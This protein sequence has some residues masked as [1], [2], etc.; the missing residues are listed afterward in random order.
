MSDTANLSFEKAVQTTTCNRQRLSEVIRIRLADF[1]ELDSHEDIGPEDAFADLGTDSRQAVE[2]KIL[3][4]ELFQCRL[5]TTVLF[6]YPTV[7]RLVELLFQKLSTG[8]ATLVED[9]MGPLPD[10]SAQLQRAASTADVHDTRTNFPLSE[11][12]KGLW[13]ISQTLDCETSFN[14]P[15]L[16]RLTQP[17]D[18]RRFDSALRAVAQRHPVMCVQFRVQED[19]G[20][21][22]QQ[23]L[24]VES[25]PSIER[26]WPGEGQS[27]QAMFWQKLR[28]PIA[29][30]GV[31]PIRA[32][33]GLDSDGQDSDR[34]GNDGQHYCLIVFHHIILDGLSA[35]PLSAELWR[36]YENDDYSS[37]QSATSST[38]DRK[39]WEYLD[40]EADYLTSAA[41]EAD[42]NY[43]QANLA[44]ANQHLELLVTGNPAEKFVD[45]VVQP[46]PISITTA[47]D[48]LSRRLHAP[49]STILLAAYYMLLYR[50]SGN[51]VISVST[52]VSGRPGGNQG[53]WKDA[54]GCFINLMV[55]TCNLDSHQTFASLVEQV[56][57]EF[58]EGL[59]HSQLPLAQQFQSIN[60]SLLRDRNNPFPISFTYQNIFSTWTVNQ[61]PQSLAE[62]DFSIYQEIQDDLTLEVY[63]FGDQLRLNWKF[64]RR[65]FALDA[66]E[67]WAQVFESLLQQIFQEPTKAIGSFRLVSDVSLDTLRTANDKRACQFE[68]YATVIQWIDASSREHADRTAVVCG[69]ESFTYR[70]LIDESYRIATEIQSSPDYRPG[71]IIPVAADRTPQTLAR[72]LGIMRSQCAY[73]PVD[74]A[75]PSERLRLMLEDVSGQCLPD[76]AYVLFT[77]GTTGRPKAVPIGN[78]ALVNLCH[79]MITAYGLNP[80][81]RVLQ[82]AQLTF[83]MSVEEIFPTLCVGAAVILREDEDLQADRFE[84]LVERNAV[85]ILNLPP[86]YHQALLSLGQ[87]RRQQLFTGVRVVAF[88]GD[89]LPLSTLL[90]VQAAGVRVFNAYGPTEACVNCS[91]SELTHATS[92]H[93]GG[94]LDGAALLIVDDQHLPVPAYGSGE[95]CILGCGLSSGYLGTQFANSKFVDMHDPFTGHQARAYLT[96]DQAYY[97]SQ[98]DI[99][100]LGRTDDQF[101][102]RGHRIEPA[103]VEAALETHPLI[104]A[105]AVALINDRLVAWYTSPLAISSVELREHL[106]QRLPRIMIP[107]F[108]FLTDALP[109]NDRGKLDR[110]KLPTLTSSEIDPAVKTHASPP[111]THQQQDVFETVQAILGDTFQ[112][113]AV[114]PDATFWD[115]GGHSLLAIQ[116]VTLLKQELG[117]ELTLKEFMQAGTFY[118]L[119]VL[120]AARTKWPALPNAG[121]ATPTTVARTN[122]LSA[123]QKR[124]WFLDQLGQ[125][126]AYKIPAL[127]E[128]HGQLDIQRLMHAIERIVDRH[129]ILRTNFVRTQDGP[130][131]IIHTSRAIPLSRQHFESSAAARSWIE[132]EIE[133]PFNLATDALIRVSLSNFEPDRSWLLICLH[134]IITDGWSMRLLVNELQHFYSSPDSEWPAPSLQYQDCT[135]QLSQSVDSEAQDFWQKQLQGL[136]EA[137]LITDWARPAILSDRGDT[138]EQAIAPELNARVA[139]FCRR[140]QITTAAF[141]LGCLAIVL[142][143]RRTG[144]DL[145][146]GLPVAGRP[147]ASMSNVLGFFVN[148]VVIRLQQAE[149]RQAPI[150]DFFKAVATTLYEALEHQSFP[151]ESVI[152][153]V[154]PER[155][156]DRSPIFQVLFSYAPESLDVIPLGDCQ[157][158]AT[159]PKSDTAKFEL[160]VSINELVNG[161]AALFIEYATDLFAC[162][163]ARQLAEQLQRIA[164]QVVNTSLVSLSQLHLVTTKQNCSHVGQDVCL[165][166]PMDFS[167]AFQRQVLLN[168]G[169]M[170]IDAPG[171]SLSY[172]ELSRLVSDQMARFEGSSRPV[173]LQPLRGIQLIV[174]CIAALQ[175]GRPI[176]FDERSASPLD[177]LSGCAWLLPTSGTTGAA[178]SVAVSARGMHVH[179]QAFANLIGLSSEDRVAQYATPEFDLF[180]EEVFPTLRSGATIVIVPDECRLVPLALA[181]WATATNITVLDLPTAVFHALAD[182]EDALDQL[183]S[184]L[185]AIVAGG[186]KL[187]VDRAR[188]LAARHPAIELWNTYGPTEATI[189]CCAHRFDPLRDTEDVPLGEPIGD[190]ELIVVDPD[191]QPV[192]DGTPGELVIAGSGVALGYVSDGEI[193]SSHGFRPYPLDPDRRVYW[194]GDLVRFRSDGQLV[195]LGRTDDEVK[196]RGQRV[197][198]L[199]V[200]QMIQADSRIQAV[201]VVASNRDG[202]SELITAVVSDADV[203]Q[204]RREIGSAMP[205]AARPAKWLKV[206]QIPVNKRGKVDRRQILREAYELATDVPPPTL[207]TDSITLSVL[208]VFQELLKTNQLGIDDDF[209]L[210]G[211]HSLLAV[212]LIER[213]NDKFS[214]KLSVL[215]A[216]RYSTVSALSRRLKVILPLMSTAGSQGRSL[217]EYFPSV[218]SSKQALIILPGLPGIGDFYYPLAKS[219]SQHSPVFVLSMPGTVAGEPAKALRECAQ[220]WAE[221]LRSHLSEHLIEG[222]NF[223]AHSYSASIL[224]ELVRH[225]RA[226]LPKTGRLVI[227]DAWPHR[228]QSDSPRQEHWAL[229]LDSP[230]LQFAKPVV[231]SALSANSLAAGKLS[232]LDV[233]LV[234]AEASQTQ[235]SL[236][237][238]EPWFDGVQSHIVPG[239]H[240]SIVQSPH[241]HSWI[242][243]L[244]T[245]HPH[246]SHSHERA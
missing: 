191:G 42:T 204:L 79:A 74:S 104:K 221:Q 109:L 209:F 207:L 242:S 168:P 237:D 39:F 189:I 71:A 127:A 128:V 91:L 224:I 151:I 211:G 53:T 72:I 117:I 25:I 199:D 232:D 107:T 188:A 227:V 22:C 89:K 81:D 85:S 10:N 97:D 2:F 134:H 196:I 15:L 126:R 88:G 177:D 231:D 67:C 239:T 141:W 64:Q 208:S 214:M 157:L 160:T 152:E 23:M 52:P 27:L 61:S 155:R 35:V 200:Q 175:V 93:I 105:A 165:A 76:T 40:W 32:Y 50:L 133:R 184:Q 56:R 194:T 161:S 110:S 29:L 146:I 80:Q 130:V 182:N 47:L 203:G 222:C 83:D 136:G 44:R 218:S 84:S 120:L 167:E 41:A 166:E 240:L 129:E 51:K 17:L 65:C 14:V 186:E 226:T 172:Q 28:T 102:L 241:F 90:E 82:F 68:D 116:V 106:F 58:L 21:V 26:L 176:T 212:Q 43:W 148:T 216:F 220:V 142:R 140:L 66:I 187:S 233:H 159:Y 180:I 48:R 114:H 20:H 173:V 77:S 236:A 59:E 63:D 210:C 217:V 132:D 99:H 190:A 229:L 119:I 34:Q 37:R 100:L 19:T 87:Q 96:G 113:A 122:Q 138:I 197:R 179:N 202:T 9:R 174:Q 215:D 108:Y 149:Y 73:M 124:L 137:E 154:M 243:L 8:E 170:A 16:F 181:R 4:E 150:E 11:T 225:H 213:I 6:E 201:A 169:K 70:W 156:T 78:A 49:R 178:K 45:C 95:L 246:E 234:I 86:S 185:R 55:T 205:P 193:I 24:P 69:T 135:D 163:S 228:Q 1:L 238:W 13:Y 31:P 57:Q 198:L 123:G 33:Y 5:R 12:Q 112:L 92:V 153:Q 195:F 244:N 3:L 139:T 62:F 38:V 18:E 46:L 144:D 245:Q 158:K 171:E 219:L 111:F 235:L 75:G 98:G 118:D 125:T 60:T 145:C 164:E 54:F 147:Q 223:I 103:E 36:H 131:C 162:T 206:A 7:D 143:K 121:T 101:S 30:S 192:P 230:H 94:A 183:S 115:V